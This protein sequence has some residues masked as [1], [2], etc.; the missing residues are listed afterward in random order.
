MAVALETLVVNRAVGNLLRESKTVQIRS[1]L[2][3]GAAQGM[4]LLEHSLA[5]LVSER[6]ITREEALRHAEDPRLIPG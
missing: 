5:R 4:G 3:T 6:R 1:L 2:Q